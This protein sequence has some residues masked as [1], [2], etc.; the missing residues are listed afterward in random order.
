MYRRKAFLSFWPLFA[1]LLFLY[2]NN[3]HQVFG[4]E[5]AEDY[6]NHLNLY[7]DV[8]EQDK[9]KVKPTPRIKPGSLRLLTT[10]FENKPGET[11]LLCTQP[12]MKKK[13]FYLDL[14]EVIS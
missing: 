7:R 8:R 12:Q 14:Q 1:S 9:V 4:N 10:T 3:H 13:I 11:P 5:Q 2:N 6:D